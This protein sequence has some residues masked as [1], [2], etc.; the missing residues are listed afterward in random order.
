MPT[1][2]HHGVS[3]TTGG[4][5]HQ[6]A[7]RLRPWALAITV[8][9]MLPVFVLLVATDRAT[10]PAGDP[11]GIGAYVHTIM[12]W[13]SVCAAL[14]VGVMSLVQ[15][16][17]TR[18]VSLLVIGVAFICAGA[19]DAFHTLAVDGIVHTNARPG[20]MTPFTWMLSRLFNGVILTFGVALFA[21][22][23]FKRYRFTT[24]SLIAVCIGFVALLSLTMFASITIEVIPRTIFPSSLVARPYDLIP[25]I[26]YLVGAFIVFPMYLH[27]RGG[28]FA[29]A[30]V[31]SMIPAIATQLYMALGSVA[32]N[33]WAFN[34]A[35]VLK[36]AGYLVPAAGL[37]MEYMQTYKHADKLS[38][39][40]SKADNA[41]VLIDPD[42]RIE[43]VNTAWERMT[44]CTFD[45]VV[46]LGCGAIVQGADSEQELTPIIWKRLSN[47]KVYE[48]EM[49]WR[50]TLGDQRWYDLSVR[51]M[52]DEHGRIIHHIGVMRDVSE[53]KYTEANMNRFVE[54]LLDARVAAETAD[55]IKSQFLAN[56]SHEIRT[57]MTAILGYTDLLE[58]ESWGRQVALDHIRVIKTNGE[59]LLR[60]I[61]DILDYSS[62]EAG[63]MAISRV[64]CSPSAMIDEVRDLLRVRADEKGLMLV[65]EQDGPIPETIETDPTRLRQILINL[66]NNAIKFTETGGV[67]IRVSMDSEGP[68]M[69]FDVVDTGVGLEKKDLGR[70]FQ[71]FSQ[72]DYSLTRRVGGTGL[73]LSI[74]RSLVQLLG[75]TISVESEPGIGSTFTFTIET[76]PL[77]GVAMVDPP[78]P[79]ESEFTL[80]ESHTESNTHDVPAPDVSQKPGPEATR[81][82]PQTPPPQGQTLEGRIL[83]AEDGPDN[84]RLISFF[85]KK[86][87]AE[88][89]V[90]ENG[91]LALD[92]ALAASE[93]GQPF[94]L[95]L[96][97][98]QMP[99]MDG[100]QATRQL[101]EKGYARPIVALTA[102][103]MPGDRDKCLRAGCDDYAGKPVK[104]PE[105]V[106]LCA[107]WIERAKATAGA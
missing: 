97:D 7:F 3:S 41:V 51:P 5:E 20:D 106:S 19:M 23:P 84:Q 80:S 38:L 101:R 13:T 6:G 17:L 52:H 103:T 71:S 76:G 34:V 26:P 74:S 50:T 46:G 62:I 99:V 69:R 1:K 83:L 2:I 107:E 53:R 75:G 72:A 81:E 35:H 48:E 102:H 58:E 61:N 24:R 63:Q 28:P 49:L 12:E 9:C 98:M 89:E 11:V 40:V 77:A 70:I 66:A 60:V 31:L 87:G 88:I 21:V 79:A 10:V 45:G 64:R 47:G 27:Y 32:A 18:E 55:K 68:L 56:M 42:G 78:K 4:P 65:I 36:S 54:E 100:Y 15:H 25:L 14:C 90:V 105:L 86:A 16:R 30:L 33:D 104:K 67:T 92:A 82:P 59:H 91:K 95:I 8:A 85:L 44:G 29:A 37:C 96:M 39:A 22:H 43:W 57:P 73:G 93:G 94:D